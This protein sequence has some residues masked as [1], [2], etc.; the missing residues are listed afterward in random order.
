MKSAARPRPDWTLWRQIPTVKAWE[1]VALS[2][3]IDP[4]VVQRIDLRAQDAAAALLDNR[5]GLMSKQWLLLNP[6]PR[7]RFAESQEFSDRLE[8]TVRSEDRLPSAVPIGAEDHPTER[9]VHMSEF[10]ALAQAL[11]WRIP[12]D[13]ERLAKSRRSSDF[14]LATMQAAYDELYAETGKPPSERQ[15]AERTGFHRD[16]IKR[17]R[18]QLKNRPN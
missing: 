14:K 18:S 16:T 7:V 8:V 4:K 9:R 1:A 2:L 15:I 5:I 3:D 10:A 17:R 13:L 6:G 11:G 12:P